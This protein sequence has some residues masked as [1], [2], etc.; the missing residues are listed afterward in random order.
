MF[1]NGNT[2]ATLHYG[3]HEI[4]LLKVIKLDHCDSLS[5]LQKCEDRT[6]TQSIKVLY[7]QAIMAERQ[8]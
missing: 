1:N 7:I 8:L 4:I 5:Y 3:G 2:I 6:A